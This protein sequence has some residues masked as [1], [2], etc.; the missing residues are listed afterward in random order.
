[1]TASTTG[2]AQTPGARRPWLANGLLAV[3]S[4]LFCL[5]VFELGARLFVDTSGQAPIPIRDVDLSTRIAFLPGRE[6]LY[7]TPEFRY[8]VKTNRFGRRD[9]EWSD[10]ELA[11]EDNLLFVGDSFVMGASVEDEDSIPTRLEAW[12]KAKGTPREVFN[13]GMAGTGIPQYAQ[14]LEDALRIGVKARTVLL[15]VFVGNDFQPGS[16]EPVDALPP[17]AAAPPRFAPHS[18]LLDVLRL[19][20][21]HS[22]LMVGWMLQLGDRLGVRLYNTDNSYIFLRNPQRDEIETFDRIL[23][24]LREIQEIC[25][26]QQRDLAIVIFPNKIQVENHDSLS[27]S[28]YDPERPNQ[29]IAEYCESRG[30]R[31][32][33]Q[34]AVLSDAY[35]REG[36]P[37]YF[38]TDRHL[39]PEGNRIA[40]DS[41]AVSLERSMGFTHRGH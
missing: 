32:W 1:M 14:I 30:L 15:G 28:I 2:S 31:C 22:P 11:D 3:G 24:K 16:L 8:T 33:D 38:P 25:E 4:V 13:F 39:N 21:S 19:R 20:V 36:R 12:T 40:A 5:L 26:R 29:R 7:E 6:R 27:T 23:D 37:L 34:L 18:L 9:R 35:S 10:A 17:V 41:I